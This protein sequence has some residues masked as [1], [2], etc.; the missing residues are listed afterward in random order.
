LTSFHWRRRWQQE[1]FGRFGV[2][3]IP[4]PNCPNFSPPTSL[5]ELWHGCAPPAFN[6][7]LEQMLWRLSYVKYAP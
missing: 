5:Q 7:G 4:P 2:W 1:N 6:S 3:C